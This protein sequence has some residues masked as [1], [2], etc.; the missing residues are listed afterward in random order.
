V[1]WITTHAFS[2]RAIVG[3]SGRRREFLHVD[4]L[5]DAC[6][7]LMENYGEAEHIDVGTGVD[8]SIRELAELIRGIVYPR[9]PLGV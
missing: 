5:A 4:D 9:S 1:N 7:F 2:S 3:W 8:L 6:T